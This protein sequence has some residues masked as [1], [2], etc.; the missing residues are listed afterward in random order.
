MGYLKPEL[1]ATDH[2]YCFHKS[3][4]GCSKQCLTSR[5][6]M[7]QGFHLCYA[8]PQGGWL[9]L[10]VFKT[11]PQTDFPHLFLTITHSR[12]SK[13]DCLCMSLSSAKAKSSHFRGCPPEDPR[14]RLRVPQ[15]I[16]QSLTYS[17]AHLSLRSHHRGSHNMCIHM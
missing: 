6:F 16:P 4:T 15:E 11:H 2:H 12:V 8:I 17:T 9:D 3:K 5:V 13:F 1:P 7:I 14:D 10:H